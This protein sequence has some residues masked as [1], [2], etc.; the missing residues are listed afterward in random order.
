LGVGV[1]N[2]KE[3]EPE[4]GEGRTTSLAAVFRPFTTHPPMLHSCVVSFG[5][6]FCFY[7]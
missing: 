2:R 6:R 1:R 4:S 7:V 5:V 3:L